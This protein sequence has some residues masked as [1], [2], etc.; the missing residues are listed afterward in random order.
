VDVLTQDSEYR[1]EDPDRLAEEVRHLDH[2]GI[3]RNFP[4]EEKG[5]LRLDC[6]VVLA[7]FDCSGTLPRFSDLCLI[8]RGPARRSDPQRITVRLEPLIV[9]HQHHDWTFA[10]WYWDCRAARTGERERWGVTAAELRSVTGEGRAPVV[11]RLEAESRAGTLTPAGRAMLCTAYQDAGRFEDAL[12]LC[13][14]EFPPQVSGLLDAERP[15][16]PGPDWPPATAWEERSARLR[17]ALW[18][19]APWRFAEAVQRVQARWAA[20]AAKKPGR[21]RKS[22]PMRMFMFTGMKTARRP[23]L[24]LERVPGGAR[25]SIVFTAANVAVAET[26]WQRPVEL[27]VARW[28]RKGKTRRSR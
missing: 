23:G 14:I 6:D 13:G 16:L 26:A 5:R 12:R 7:L 20:W 28:A 19:A 25:L 24:M 17:R 22:A 11:A 4:R 2:E 1:P 8:A 10:R 9:D 21:G 3:A 18:L 15:K 27:D